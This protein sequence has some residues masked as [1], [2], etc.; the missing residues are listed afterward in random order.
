[1]Q[2][3]WYLKQ[4]RESCLLFDSKSNNTYKERSRKDLTVPK[5]RDLQAM[6]QAVCQMDIRCWKTK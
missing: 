2:L 6:L 1:M 4:S 5:T 3:K